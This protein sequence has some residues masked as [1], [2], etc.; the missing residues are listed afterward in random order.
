MNEAG[1]GAAQNEAAPTYPPKALAPTTLSGGEVT[2]AGLVAHEQAP[3]R[4]E[5]DLYIGIAAGGFTAKQ[6]AI[7]TEPTDPSLVEF[8]P[9]GNR[10]IG[11]VPHIEYRR[12]LA[13][14]FGPG[15]W[16]IRPLEQRI[17]ERRVLYHGALYIQ[18]RYI[19]EAWGG[20]DYH[21]NNPQ[22]AWDDALE[23]AKS[24]C[25]TRCC[26]DLGMF[27][28]AWEP[29]WCD[30]VYDERMAQK[31]KE[32]PAHAPTAPAMTRGAP[33]SLPAA[34]APPK[35]LPPAGAPDP[36][37]LPELKQVLGGLLRQLDPKLAKGIWDEVS[38]TQTSAA[39]K[40]GIATARRTIR[41]E[42]EKRDK[43]TPAA[44]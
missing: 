34:T 14:A 16:A 1:P 28:E 17:H 6:I 32:I 29:G 19:A 2:P 27:S 23:G 5:P 24:N 39:V 31:R 13:R 22:M 41:D 15:A 21:P 11:S 42:A 37:S 9:A 18:G 10:M 43:K 8:K 12:R 30:R 7:L 36:E 35:V 25:L 40:V 44:G 3:T 33:P 38:K 20:N 26:K 4:P